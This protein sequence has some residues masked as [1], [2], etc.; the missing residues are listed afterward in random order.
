MTAKT[1]KPDLR[2]AAAVFG[3]LLALV[4]S[5]SQAEERG[6]GGRPPH[7]EFD[8]RFHHDRYY[9]ARGY[10]VAGLPP[11]S[12]SIAYGRE[13]FYF[14]AG[15]W[16]RPVGV[17]FVVVDPPIGIVVPQMPMGCAMVAVGPQNYCYANGVYYLPGSGGYVVSAPPPPATNGSTLPV[18]VPA[19]PGVAPS[20]PALLSTMRP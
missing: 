7:W 10:V 19:L 18:P 20:T 3:L 5:L 4:P 16:F 17:R 1:F 14:Q 13:R 8:G 2:T 6:H 11:G 12:V 15:V 9:P